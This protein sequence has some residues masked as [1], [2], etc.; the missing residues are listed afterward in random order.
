MQN[1]QDLATATAVQKDAVT[2][3]NCKLTKSTISCRY[4]K[5]VILRSVNRNITAHEAITCNFYLY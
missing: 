3:M 4:K 1:R 2:V 5:D